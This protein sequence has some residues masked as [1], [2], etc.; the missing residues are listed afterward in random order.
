MVKQGSHGGTA[1]LDAGRAS[2][3][4]PA[5]EAHTVGTLAAGSGRWCV[6]CLTDK[7]E[8]IRLC[9][10]IVPGSTVPSGLSIVL[11]YRPSQAAVTCVWKSWQAGRKSGPLQLMHKSHQPAECPTW[12]K[13]LG[14]LRPRC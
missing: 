4:A 8:G 12:K 5:A 3:I 13:G 7:A 9:A 10:C 1:P 6:N 2:E 11:S 14:S